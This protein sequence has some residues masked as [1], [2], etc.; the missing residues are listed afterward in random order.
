[1]S[2][3]VVLHGA[4]GS[5]HQ[6]EPLRALLPDVRLH[7][8]EFHGH[9]AA[10]EIDAPWTIDLFADQLQTY[11]QS[12]RADLLSDLLPDLLSDLPVLGYSMGGYVALRLA[13]RDSS[14][15]RI[16]TL[17]SKLDWSPDGA[18]KEIKMLDADV[19]EAKVPA[20]AAD[21]QRRHGADRWRT[22]LAKTADMMIG[23][24]NDPVLTEGDMAKISIPVRYGLGDRDEMVT[25]DET[26]RFYRATPGAE[27]V[28][29]PGTRH[30]IEKVRPHLLV[31]Q[32]RSFL[33]T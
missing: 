5:A 24:G 28:V 3:L 1:M 30:P 21:L 15:S 7:I 11:L 16:L 18:A 17:G 10:A 23:L 2:D 33:L 12:I 31:E 25:L 13:Q 8:L 27:L 19:I 14:I 20:F 29:L 4:L 6:F 26:A 9:G 22:V 32:I